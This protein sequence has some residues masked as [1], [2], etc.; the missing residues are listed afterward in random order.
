[1]ENQIEIDTVYKYE[2]SI[3]KRISNSIDNNE[4]IL[5]LDENEK[6]KSIVCLV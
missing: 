6:L 4:S 1:M 3:E 5:K 2:D